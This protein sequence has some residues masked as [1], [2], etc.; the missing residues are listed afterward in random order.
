[1]SYARHE[2]YQD[3]EDVVVNTN[4]F[5]GMLRDENLRLMYAEQEKAFIDERIFKNKWFSI[6]YIIYSTL[7]IF[8]FTY[9]YSIN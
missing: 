4:E 3:E 6:F 2:A 1:M 7:S 8:V 5:Y 9:I